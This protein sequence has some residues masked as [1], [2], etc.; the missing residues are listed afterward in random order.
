MDHTQQD[1]RDRSWWDIKGWLVERD[2]ALE[3]ALVTEDSNSLNW[4]RASYVLRFGFVLVGIYLLGQDGA[5]EQAGRW[6][7]S[8]FA[9]LGVM[10][11]QRRARSFRSGWL[12]GQERAQR[13]SDAVPTQHP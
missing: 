10:S 7:I 13:T 4:L 9:V 12:E 1:A 6:V 5:W 2:R 8:A 11:T 3:R